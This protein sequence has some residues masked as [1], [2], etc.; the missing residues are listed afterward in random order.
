MTQGADILVL[1]AGVFGVTAACELQNRGYQVALLD[2]GV[3]TRSHPLAASTDISKVVRMEYGADEFYMALVE[4][5]M[6]GFRQWNE[7][8]DRPLFHED[9][10]LMLTKHTMQPGGF[11][12]DSYQMLL[13]RGHSPQRLDC[14]SLRTRFPA[15]S[16]EEYVDGFFHA[17]GGYVES[18]ALVDALQT[19][20]ASDG[21]TLIDATAT[22]I[23]QDRDK[24]TGV[25]TMDGRLI[26]ADHVVVS[27]GAWTPVLIPELR[28][29]VRSTGHPV[30]HLKPT[31]PKD[32][33][34]PAFLTFTADIARTGWY[35]FPVHP[36]EGV[37]KIG[38]HAA[39]WP[40]DPLHDERTVPEETYRDLRAFLASTFPALADAE[41]TYTRR[42]LYA[43][44]PDGDYWIDHH[45]RFANLTVA[46]GGNG[47]GFK[48]APL[49]GGLI[50]DRVLGVNNPRLDRFAWRSVN[51][52]EE[53][54]EAC[55]F[56]G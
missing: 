19:K 23:K 34:T 10:I 13:K 51:A 36:S 15:W 20:A 25:R 4:E 39:G 49:L 16:T 14:D 30:F 5:A 38:R 9:G 43:D 44:T 22:D 56:T 31:N 50:A 3:G 7:A 11:E 8:L 24:A 26:E 33:E 12:H 52:S 29:T 45:P 42:C 6:D 18:G 54:M 17:K 1:G 32:F 46:T 2:Q 35:G 48:M 40:T 47:H 53:R 27:C 37:V 55:R 41:V 28:S 21:V